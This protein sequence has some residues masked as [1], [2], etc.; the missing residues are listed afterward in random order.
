MNLNHDREQQPRF[1][2]VVFPEACLACGGP[3]AARLSP[4]TARGVC[5]ACHVV[6]TLALARVADGF[7]VGQVPSG[8]A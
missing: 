8:V 3:L 6:T 2:D 1:Q 7:Q 5:L 4:A